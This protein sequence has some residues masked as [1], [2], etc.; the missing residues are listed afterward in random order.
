VVRTN[1][2]VFS[3]SFREPEWQLGLRDHRGGAGRTTAELDVV[4]ELVH[5]L[6]R[7]H[8]L[9]FGEV[10]AEEEHIPLVHHVGDAARLLAEIARD[11]VL[12]EVS[13]RGE[14]DDRLAV[15]ELVAHQSR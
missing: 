12:R 10:L 11:V 1:G 14:D 6:V 4:L 2:Q 8:V 9:D 15:L 5:H 7:H 13:A 3:H